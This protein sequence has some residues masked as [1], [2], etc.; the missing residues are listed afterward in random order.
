M[1][2][3][4]K[5]IFEFKLPDVGE[6]IHEAEVL[7]WRVKVGDTVAADQ[8]VVEIQTDKAV[9]EIP[10]PVAGRVI[11]ICLESGALAHTGDVLV[12]IDSS[13]AGSLSTARPE[14]PG[15]ATREVQIG[16]PPPLAQN[17]TDAFTV[18]PLR[19]PLATLAQ[20]RRTLAAPVVRKLALELGVELSQVAGSGPLERIL[21]E[22]VRRFAAQQTATPAP[23][24]GAREDGEGRNQRLSPQIKPQPVISPEAASGIPAA[25]S[26]ADEPVERTQLQGLRRRIAERMEA[27][28]RVPHVTS[29]EEVDATQLVA[30]RESLQPE[31]QQRGVRLTYLPLILKATVQALKEFPYINAR[32]D[33]AGQEILLFRYY[34]IGIATATAAG[35]LVPV[36][37]HADRLTILQV[38]AEIE[39]LAAGARQR[40][41]SLAELSGSTFT[42]T[43]FG[44]FGGQQGTPIINPPEVA[45]LGC[46]RIEAKAVVVAGQIVAR[47]ILPL[48]LS[49]DHRLIDGAMAAQFLGRLKSLLENPNLLF[50]ELI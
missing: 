20:G 32:L 12:K 19:D 15:R 9:V 22:D 7:A 35:L 31:A 11:E 34:H 10:T 46:G 37:R 24:T 6:G 30:L 29:F 16:Q 43:N 23:E 3:A 33:M 28:W 49:F 45:I 50:L 44:S 14:A 17:S 38:A 1:P 13:Q 26:G 36:V 4:D 40:S 41:L 25:T 21:P 39:R 18:T 5:K 8:P 2:D 27:A 42:I 48:A 47:P